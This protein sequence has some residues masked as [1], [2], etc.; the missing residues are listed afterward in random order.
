MQL[1]A[2][3]SFL[4]NVFKVGLGGQ[5]NNVSTNLVNGLGINFD[6]IRRPNDRHYAAQ[7]VD[8]INPLAPAFCAMRYADGTDAA[9][10]YDGA[11]HKAF[12]MGFPMECINNVRSRQ[13]VMKAVMTFLAK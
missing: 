4:S 12:I 7:S 11:D 2:E 13:Q 5:N 9:V 10:A 3:R 8:I 1:D 6:I